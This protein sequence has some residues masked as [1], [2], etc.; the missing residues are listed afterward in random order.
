ME[1]SKKA[2]KHSKVM[3]ESGENIRRG[4]L[5][6]EKT[7]KKIKENRI[8]RRN[9]KKKNAYIC[10]WRRVEKENIL[11]CTRKM[12]ERLRP[13]CTIDIFVPLFLLNNW[14]K[15][16]SRIEHPADFV[17]FHYN[18]RSSKHLNIITNLTKV[19]TWEQNIY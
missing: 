6:C 19:W 15:F 5:G 13:I 2:K 12:I 4:T 3:K 16:T 7:L 9:K 8:G 11:I 1:V 14:I 17:S 18:K 10:V